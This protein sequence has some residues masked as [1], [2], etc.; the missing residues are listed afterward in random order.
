MAPAGRPPTGT[1][2]AVPL[3]PYGGADDAVAHGA[4]WQALLHPVPSNVAEI[5]KAAVQCLRYT[6]ALPFFRTHGIR[7]PLYYTV[8]RQP[9]RNNDFL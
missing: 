6:I 3:Q 4:R 7:R 2:A 1:G 5:T 8:G 9:R